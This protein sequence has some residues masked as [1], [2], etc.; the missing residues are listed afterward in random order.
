MID[1]IVH[2]ISNTQGYLGYAVHAREF[3]LGMSQHLAL[4]CTQW[5][6]NSPKHYDEDVY[7]DRELLRSH[8]PDRP[9]VSIGLSL[10]S[11]FY[12]LKDAPG[13]RIGYTVWDSTKLPDHWAEPLAMVDRIWVPSDW[14]RGVLADND[15]DPER[16]DVMPEGV[17]ATVFRPDGPVAI[18]VA[19]LPGFKFINV[20]KFED[21]KATAEMMKAFDRN[22]RAASLMRLRLPCMRRLFIVL[23]IFESRPCK[24]LI[25]SSN[26]L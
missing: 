26:G 3:F 18:N 15:V 23:L 19:K 6:Q 2:T 14:A 17:N 13:P 8:F 11:A 5:Q 1:P 22:S 25:I 24:S 21:R 10:G 7:R 9:L 4:T 16:V 12:I 20:G